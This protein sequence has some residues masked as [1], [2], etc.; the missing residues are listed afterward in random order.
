MICARWFYGWRCCLP[1]R[2]NAWDDPPAFLQLCSLP[3]SLSPTHEAEAFEGSA[4]A[5]H[6]LQGYRCWQKPATEL[7][8]EQLSEGFRARAVTPA[9]LHP[10]NATAR[11]ARRISR[12]NPRPY[13]PRACRAPSS[14]RKLHGE[15]RLPGTAAAIPSGRARFFSGS[16]VLRLPRAHPYFIRSLR[17]R[18]R[19][20]LP[21]G[22]TR[23]CSDRGIYIKMKHCKKCWERLSQRKCREGE[24][25]GGSSPRRS[26]LP[27]ARGSGRRQ[28][29]LR[30][31]LWKS[32]TTVNKCYN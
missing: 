23:V 4:P 20:R 31:G 22:W 32:N 30:R 14:A 6:A 12:S 16:L 17:Q 8:Q 7:V 24:G 25:L 29:K 19:H 9:S 2:V 26:E 21:G 28:V 1:Q 18:F 15:R 10:R 5:F 11:S 13:P 3:K 27:R